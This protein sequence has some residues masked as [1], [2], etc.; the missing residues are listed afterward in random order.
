[1]PAY[2][3]TSQAPSGQDIRVIMATDLT[4]LAA[5]IKPELGAGLSI[6]NGQREPIVVSVTRLNAAALITPNADSNQAAVQTTTDIQAAIADLPA[7]TVTT[8][9]Q[10][11][12]AVQAIRTLLNT[13]LAELRAAEM[14][15]P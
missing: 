11:N 10:A 6:N 3:V 8:V 13:L 12:T 14:I 7:F 4:D 2:L 9:A 5:K 1:M 15:T